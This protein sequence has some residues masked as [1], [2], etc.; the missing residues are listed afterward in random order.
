MLAVIK[1]YALEGI[2]GFPVNIETDIQPG[3]PCFDIVGLPSSSVKESRNRVRAAVKNSSYDFCPKRVTVNLAPADVKKEGS[4]YDFPI[5]VGFLVGTEQL[6]PAETGKYI[7]MGE[8]SLDGAVRRINGV[9]PIL[10]SAYQQGYKKFIIPYDNAAEAS[11]IDGIEAYPVKSLSEACAFLGGIHRIEPVAFRAYGA[12]R[13]SNKYG[14]DLADVKGQAA[15]KRALE[16]AVAGGHNLLMCGAPGAG[17][18]ML[19]KCV[20]TIM[21]DMTFEEAIETTKIH[22]VAGVLNGESGIVSARPFR[23]PHH[24]AS[25]FSLTG[26]GSN[27][28]PGEIS[29]AHN[30]VLFLDEMPEYSKK[31]LET[32]RQPLEDGVITVSRVARTVEYPARFMLIASMNPCPCGYDGSRIKECNCTPL[33]K[34][35]YRSRLSGPLLDRIDIYADVDGVEYNELRDEKYAETSETVRKRVEKAR[36]VQLERY[37]G[38]GFY[39]NSRMQG[40]HIKKYCALDGV[41]EKL[42]EAAFKRFKLSARGATRIL[43]TARTIADLRGSGG[44]EPSDLAEAIQYRVRN[45]TE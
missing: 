43:K 21:P 4:I 3:I 35:R 12:A 37:K 5:A 38:E 23:T 13:V 39:T 9:M 28:T 8:L 16:I 24:T 45:I 30:G 1:S 19:A 42:L 18:T 44:I 29:L 25:L 40:G 17:K 6:P 41:S 34:K 33:E 36:A 2:E 14:V 7:I 20:P 15:A 27:S 31:T 22:S 10:I 32:L 11:F 26:G